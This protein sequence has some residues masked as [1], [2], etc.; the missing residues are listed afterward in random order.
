MNP[1]EKSATQ[2][3]NKSKINKLPVN[4]K[5]IA[6]DNHYHILEY[7]RAAKLLDHLGLSAYAEQHSGFSV[8]HADTF[9]ILLSDRLTPESE[10]LVIAHEIGHIQLHYKND[11]CM[12]GKDDPQQEK[13]ADEF[14]R[15]LLAPL[16]VLHKLDIYNAEDIRKY[17]GL[18]LQDAEIILDQLVN[19]AEDYYSVASQKEI[20]H[21]FFKYVKKEG[22]RDKK[23]ILIW[24]VILPTASVLTISVLLVMIATQNANNQRLAD[25]LSSALSVVAQSGASISALDENSTEPASTTN[26][27]VTTSS[28][29]AAD[30]PN[31]TNPDLPADATYYW[32]DGGSVFHL[33]ADCQSLIHA[34]DVHSGTLEE[35]ENAKDR[36]CKFCQ[37]R[38]AAE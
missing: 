16:P 27:A 20:E 29:E 36:I 24:K 12:I 22:L 9:Y 18:S 15:L 28:A 19:Y 8:R 37:S 21:N 38:I 11:D 17:T 25:S 35:A 1:V 3:L 23:S 4:V 7:K 6:K 30:S 34:T 14:A 33:F 2:I 26:E 32:T 10:R 31:D 13:E 5:Q